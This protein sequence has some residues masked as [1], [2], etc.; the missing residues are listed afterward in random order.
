MAN[1]SQINFLISSFSQL[2][3][4]QA[5]KE[6]KISKTAELKPFSY[7]QVIQVQIHFKRSTIVYKFH[8]QVHDSL[9]ASHKSPFDVHQLNL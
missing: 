1:F 5:A 9:S 3:A 7:T 6:K 2:Y 4:E 8:A